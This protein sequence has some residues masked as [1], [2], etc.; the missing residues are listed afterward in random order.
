VWDAEYMTDRY[1]AVFSNLVGRPGWSWL[2]PTAPEP[3]QHLHP[4]E[5]FADVYGLCSMSPH[6]RHVYVRSVG[7]YRSVIG[8]VRLSKA[9]V[10]DTCWLIHHA[11]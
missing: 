10:A 8:G 7:G 11:P 6:A 3:G 5:L 4:G 9:V 1:R 2:D